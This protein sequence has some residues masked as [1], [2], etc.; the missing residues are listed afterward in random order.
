MTLW[1]SSRQGFKIRSWNRTHLQA[2]W[3]NAWVDC[4]PEFPKKSYDWLNFHIVNLGL[5]GSLWIWDPWDVAL[6]TNFDRPVLSSRRGA[7][8]HSVRIVFMATRWIYGQC[9]LYQILREISGFLAATCSIFF[10]CFLL[11]LSVCHLVQGR[12]CT[13]GSSGLCW[14]KQLL[15]L[16]TSWWERNNS[17]CVCHTLLNRSADIRGLHRSSGSCSTS[18]AYS[19]NSAVAELQMEITCAKSEEGNLIKTACYLF[20]SLPSLSIQPLMFYF[21]L[22][23]FAEKMSSVRNICDLGLVAFMSSQWLQATKHILPGIWRNICN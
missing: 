16:D 14:H 5:A 3:Y 22:G 23:F 1:P 13:V 17:Q 7:A 20:F 19:K 2:R 8:F 10:T 6:S 12:Y 4:I 11:I 15:Y 18:F 9:S 21:V